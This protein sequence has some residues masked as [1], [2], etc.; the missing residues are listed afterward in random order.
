MVVTASCLV[1]STW[2]PALLTG[3]PAHDFTSDKHIRRCITALSLQ[4]EGV[5]NLQRL[6]DDIKGH[7][8]DSTFPPATHKQTREPHIP[9]PEFAPKKKKKKKHA[10]A[11]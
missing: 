6:T 9:A 8:S 2:G 10:T 3:A 4:T 1:Y 5:K 11:A 7:Y